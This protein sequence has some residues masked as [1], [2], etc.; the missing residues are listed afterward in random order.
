MSLEELI[1]KKEI[2]TY[3]I[4]RLQSMINNLRKQLT[5]TNDKIYQI[6]SHHWIVDVDCMNIDHTQYVC[7]I[8]H[9][10]KS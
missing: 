3:E 4:F 7:T 6:C 9:S 8:C 5:I 10:H 1:D 2:I